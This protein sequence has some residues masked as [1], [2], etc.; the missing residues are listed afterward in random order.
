MRETLF[1]AEFAI[2]RSPPPNEIRSG[3]GP[4]AEL[5]RTLR[6]SSLSRYT[7][8][9][10]MIETQTE[11]PPTARS[12]TQ[13]CSTVRCVITFS[14][15]S[16]FTTAPLP[17]LAAQTAPSANTMCIPP[18]MPSIGKRCRM[19][20]LFGS[21]RT[22]P[23]PEA[24]PSQPSPTPMPPSPAPPRIATPPATLARGPASRPPRGPPASD[25][26]EAADRCAGREPGRCDRNDDWAAAATAPREHLA[27][28]RSP[29]RSHQLIASPVAVVG[30]LCESGLE[31]SVE[32]LRE[33]RPNIAEARRRIV[34]VG[35]EDG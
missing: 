6:S 13:P 34:Q 22:T 11:P 15:G 14:A 10:G 7:T 16:I 28:Q 8:P 17:G 35:E 32:R 21:T 9:S 18:E 27:L 19:R 26:G 33:V 20:P 30:R 1:A 29:R 2:Q 5:L 3:S 25:P 31:D 24:T 12:L 23:E 4:A